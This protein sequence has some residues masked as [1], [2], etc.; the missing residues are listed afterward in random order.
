VWF[1]ADFLSRHAASL[2]RYGLP[3]TH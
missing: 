1:H 3:A 2:Q